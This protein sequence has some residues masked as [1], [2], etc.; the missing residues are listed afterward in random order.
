[1]P[2]WEFAITLDRHA[3]FPVFRQIARA[4]TGDITRGRLAPG[5]RLPGSR[6]LARRLDVNRNTVLAAY[7]ELIAEGWVT[8]SAASGTFV[9]RCLPNRPRAAPRRR[10]AAAAFGVRPAPTLPRP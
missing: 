9:S 4:I 1:M 8:A 10:P 3:D 5:A 7:E 2:Q 6:T